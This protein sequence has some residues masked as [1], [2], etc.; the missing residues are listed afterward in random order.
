MSWEIRQYNIGLD[1]ELV[2]IDIKL[3]D[4]ELK[5][6]IDKKIVTI[7][8]GDSPFDVKNI[9][10][11][12]KD[13]L[14]VKSDNQKKGAIA[15]FFINLY[16]NSKN[17]KQE[18]LFSNLEENSAKK[19]FDGFYSI[20]EVP[21]YME[22]KSGSITTSGISHKDKVNDA[23][24]DLKDKF[25]GNVKNDPWKNAYHHA[26][27]YSVNTSANIKKKLVI[28]SNDFVNGI[29]HDIA[30][31]NIIP[32]ATI[33]LDNKNVSIDKNIMSNDITLKVKNYT[34]N[35]IIIICVTQKSIDL[36][37]NYLDM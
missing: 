27:E 1:G 23:Y 35:K 24:N 6:L 9:K 13:Y 30:E 17:Y 34:Y 26:N 36:F 2:A 7:C 28:Y 15:E 11:S 32:C 33:F 18:C 21:W 3:I 10:K 20:N 16:L 19:G 31:F 25:S 5:S 14:T 37:L 22:S 12:L 29:S 4:F 8:E